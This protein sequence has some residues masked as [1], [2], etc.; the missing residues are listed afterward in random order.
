MVVADA[1]R[2]AQRRKDG[3][4]GTVHNQW[5]ILGLVDEGGMGAIYRGE[6]REL[7]TPVAIK[8]LLPYL[9]HDAEAVER[10]RQEAVIGFNL[11]HPN[12]ARVLDMFDDESGRRFVVMDWFDGENLRDRLARGPCELA[13]ARRIFDGMC[14]GV[15]AAHAEG[16]IHR[17]I[18]PANVFLARGPRG[19]IPKV[20]DFGISRLTSGGG[21]AT[22]T[23]KAVGTP[24]YMSPEQ[25]RD[26]RSVSVRSDI[27]ALGLV[28]YELLT[29]NNP[30]DDEDYL[31][32]RLKVSTAP[33]PPHPAVPPALFPLLARATAKRAEDRFASVEE[34]H[35]AVSETLRRP[36]VVPHS[37]SGDGVPPSGATSQ[38]GSRPPAEAPRGAAPVRPAVVLVYAPLALLAGFALTF[39]LAEAWALA[40]VLLAGAWWRH[41]AIR[42]EAYR[43][44]IT[45][46]LVWPSAAVL[47]LGL[48]ALVRPWKS[49][50]E[51]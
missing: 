47:G 42:R 27:Y 32:L 7:R 20:L 10:F 14:A 48:F 41:A 39:A 28:F 18:K 19:E 43:L 17:D 21:R 16:V 9:R 13:L 46:H 40:Q 15:A 49:R 12:L 44:L 24:A 34:F 22:Q 3:L 6:H 35:H 45:R 5:R 11:R 23:G 2:H 8:V 4:E 38:P 26:S 50:R 25:H 31:P 37:V 29:G 30:F 36:S 51:P 1:T 33:L